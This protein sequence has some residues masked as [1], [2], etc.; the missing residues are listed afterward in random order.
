MHKFVWAS[1]LVGS[2]ALVAG[3]AGAA[4]DDDEHA[5]LVKHEEKQWAQPRPDKALV[6]VVRPANVGFAIKFWAFADDKFL[7]VTKGNNYT[8]AFVEPG[9]RIFWSKAENVN[10]IKMNFQAGKTYYIQQR[11]RMG[12]IKARVKL[13]LLGEAEGKKFLEECKY[14]TPTERAVAKAQEYVE[15]NY[16]KAKE[17]ASKEK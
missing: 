12:G 10:A 16:A 15:K 1:L 11:V 13:E 8:Y 14:V 5:Y 3:P 17:A 2:L 9:E 7:G 6:Y 4:K